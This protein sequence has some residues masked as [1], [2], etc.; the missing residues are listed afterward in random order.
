MPVLQGASSAEC[1]APGA[2]V[3][4]VV[5]G[6]ADCRLPVL[7]AVVACSVLYLVWAEFIAC[8]RCVREDS[9]Q[10]FR[11]SDTRWVDRVVV[12]C[13]FVRSYEWALAL[14]LEDDCRAPWPL[15]LGA[16]DTQ[17]LPYGF[18]AVWVVVAC[19]AVTVRGL[20]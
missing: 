14:V 15:A 8:V 16:V 12:S 4:P 18:H 3:A 17:V 1:A 9:V 2:G 5:L 13:R 10:A 20:S 19:V 11:A 6:V 7:E